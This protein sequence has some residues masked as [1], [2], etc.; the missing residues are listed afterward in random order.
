MPRFHQRRDPE[1]GEVVRVPF[2]PEEEAA[3]DAEEA[4]YL[5]RV[6][7]R[8]EAHTERQQTLATKRAAVDAAATP[9]AKMDALLE[10]IEARDGP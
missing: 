8:E 10:W 1:T 6:Q 4:A 9:G 7:E 3:R 5:A 2:T